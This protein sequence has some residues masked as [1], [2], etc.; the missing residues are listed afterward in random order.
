M[1]KRFFSALLAL[2]L[3]LGT[4]PHAR[5]DGV[6]D[7]ATVKGNGSPYYIMVNRAACVVTIYTLDSA[8][9]YSVPLRAML[10]SVGADN[11]TPT[12]T[13]AVTYFKT[14]WLH[15]VD[16]SY[17]QYNTQ[18]YGNFLFH[19]V[20]YGDKSEDTLFT[21]EYN[22]LGSAVSQG[23]VRLQVADAKWIYDNCPQ[24]TTVV[25]YDDAENPGALGIPG[26]AMDYLDPDSPNANWEPTDP[27]RENP[28][29]GQVVTELSLTEDTAELTVGDRLTLAPQFTPAELTPTLRYHSS[30]PTVAT[31]DE[32]GNVTAVGAGTA[33]ISVSAGSY[34]AH[35]TVT[36]SG[37][38]LG[39][40]DVPAG[41]WYYDDVRYI[42][43]NGIMS[44]SNGLF[45]PREPL[46]RVMGL[47][48]LYNLSDD[49]AEVAREPWYA[50]ALSWA[51]GNGMCQGMSTTENALLKPLSRS[52]LI[53]LLYRFEV[54]C[55]QSTPLSDG[56]LSLFT[57]SEEV[58]SFTEEA[59][60]W[61]V[62]RGILNGDDTGRLRP[63]DVVTRAEAA[64][65]LRLY[66][67]NQPVG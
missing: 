29:R 53:V 16:D 21:D 27:D 40:S 36:V 4:V 37:T 59:L 58:N 28:W 24:G 45:L 39:F 61:A 44:G 57:D 32:R 42:S 19:S 51:M 22:D 56:D 10:C 11:K 9:Y 35:M 62:G 18:F 60:S 12:G 50:P 33:R 14:R 7:P 1:K 41:A 8:G 38:A 52:D 25:I 47:Q 6:T 65:L 23:C 3:C 5:A 67:E 17:G 20:C 66:L 46:S 15:M 26:K 55:R 31:V 13:Y 48:I 64:R 30:D 54:L 2:L 34:C 63:N 49:T 43:E